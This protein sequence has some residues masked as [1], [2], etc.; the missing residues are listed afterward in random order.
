[1]DKLLTQQDL[2]ERW[3]VSVRSIEEWRKQGVLQPAKGIPT[4]R[5]TPQYIAEPEGVELERFSPLEKRR[6]ERELEE[7]REENS[8]LKSIVMRFMTET[9]GLIYGGGEQDEQL[10][11]S[12]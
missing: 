3:Q 10:T 12:F 6:M 9:A 4:I 5:F 8:R 7:L 1:M 11:T 2:A